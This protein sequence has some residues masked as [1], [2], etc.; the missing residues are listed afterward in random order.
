MY[1]QSGRQVAQNKRMAVVIA[2]VMSSDY[3]GIG[4]F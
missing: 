2:G 1:L 3:N 4:D